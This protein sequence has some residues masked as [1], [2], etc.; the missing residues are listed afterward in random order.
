M[1]CPPGGRGVGLSRHFPLRVPFPVAAG[2][3]SLLLL[4]K[5]HLGENVGPM[6][7]QFREGLVMLRYPYIDGCRPA[8]I[9]EVRPATAWGEDDRRITGWRARLFHKRHQSMPPYQG[10]GELSGVPTDDSTRLNKT[11]LTACCSRYSERTSSRTAHK[12]FQLSQLPTTRPLPTP[13]DNPPQDLRCFL[14][15]FRPHWAQ[16]SDSMGVKRRAFKAAEA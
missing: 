3:N 5:M 14:T 12:R 16:N 11:C 7:G 10:H 1:P 15:V 9:G 2:V 8:R 13:P 6:V 4:L